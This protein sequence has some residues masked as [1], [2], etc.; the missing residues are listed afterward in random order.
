LTSDAQIEQ[1]G[2]RRLT[3]RIARGVGWI[4][5]G[6][7]G[8]RGVTLIVNVAATK[9]L[10]P[11][12]VGTLLLATSIVLIGATVAR[13]GMEFAAVRLLARS[14]AAH[15]WLRARATVR[16]TFAGTVIGS[17]ILGGILLAGGW[18]WL[19][20]HAFHSPGMASLETSASVLLFLTA[21][22]QTVSNWFRALQR[23]RA[24]A[25]YDELVANV[26]WCIPLLVLWAVHR[27]P[28]VDTLVWLRTGG[29]LLVL[30]AMLALF[31]RPY[32]ELGQTGGARPS[33]R[34]LLELGSTGVVTTVVLLVIGTTSDMAILGHYRPQSEVGAY[35]L[36]ASLSALVA[37]PFIASTVVFGPILASARTQDDRARLQRPLQAIVA[38]VSLPAI[39]V[40]VIFAGVGSE[41]LGFAFGSRYTHA[42]DVLAVLSLA[43]AVFVLTG[44]CNLAL[45]MMD[46]LRVSFMLSLASAVLSV[47]LDFFAAP[48][49]GA[50]GVAFATGSAI[51]VSSVV[52]ALVAKRLTGVS[53]FARFRRADA[54]AAIAALH[55]TLRREPL[56]ERA[57]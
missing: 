52:T 7:M 13:W 39:V 21:V 6:R 50:I 31:R 46:R 17:G 15:E 56:P 24:V 19:S 16:R 57:R 4:F 8:S 47:G 27:S 20:L 25:L 45:G 48:R 18:R 12:G 49:W 10:V 14:I 51:V 42:G 54:S 38:A 30:A 22:Q 35:G 1:E 5:V 2:A 40:A 53:T 3:L 23:M 29:M 44:P 34:E 33:M 32:R 55:D 36:A 41:I 26:L 28:S 43:Q 9:L 11:A 37:A